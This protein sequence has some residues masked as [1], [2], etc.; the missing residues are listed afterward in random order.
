ML[1][2]KSNDTVQSEQILISRELKS[3]SHAER[4]MFTMSL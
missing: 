3:F 1:K 4:P 2:Y